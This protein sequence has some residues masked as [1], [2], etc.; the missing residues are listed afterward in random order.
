MKPFIDCDMLEHLGENKSYY[1][2]LA[3]YECGALSRAGRC[4][5]A[6]I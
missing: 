5:V 4:L 6:A 3:S 2:A 1:E